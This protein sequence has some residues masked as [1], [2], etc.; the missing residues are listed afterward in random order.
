MGQ[1]RRAAGVIAVLVG[2][3][4]AGDP[5]QIQ[6]RRLRPPLDLAGAEPGVEQHRRAIHLDRAAVA[7]GTRAQDIEPHHPPV[8]RANVRS[9]ERRRSGVSSTAR[10]VMTRSA[11]RRNPSA[12]CRSSPSLP[13]A[14]GGT[15]LGGVGGPNR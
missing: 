6:S 4:D 1:P 12:V 3:R 13:H 9:S 14:K 5:R 8:L 2:E 15:Y 11:T 10:R 7:A